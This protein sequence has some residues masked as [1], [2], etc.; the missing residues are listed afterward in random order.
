MAYRLALLLVTF[1]KQISSDGRKA[2][3]CVDIAYL[4]QGEHAIFH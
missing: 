2:S 4:H 3:H 1:V